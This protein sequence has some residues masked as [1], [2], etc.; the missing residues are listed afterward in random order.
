MKK[1]ILTEK[2]MELIKAHPFHTFEILSNVRGLEDIGK[3]TGYHHERSDGSGYP[4][5]LKGEEISLEAKIMAVADVFATLREFRPYRPIISKKEVIETMIN[6]ARNCKLDKGVIDVLI[7][8]YD[9]IEASF[10]NV[11]FSAMQRYREI[12]REFTTLTLAL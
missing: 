5:K 7:E 11:Q 3:W 12:W 4:F 2:E 8:N 10:L 6:E 1:E 9:D